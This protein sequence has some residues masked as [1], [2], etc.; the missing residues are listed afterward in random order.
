MAWQNLHRDIQEIFQ[1][2]EGCGDASELIGHLGMHRTPA[3]QEDT[4]QRKAYRKAWKAG[5]AGRASAKR[6][7]ESAKED[8]ERAAKLAARVQRY[9]DKRR[10]KAAEAR[11]QQGLPPARRYRPRRDQVLVSVPTI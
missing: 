9:R 10:E 4:P 11:A 1:R 5:E 2:L 7:Y 3:A 8:P 6:T